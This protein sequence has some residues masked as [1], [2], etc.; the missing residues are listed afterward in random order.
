MSIAMAGVTRVLVLADAPVLRRG[1]AGMIG[2]TAG[3]QAVGAPGEPRRAVTLAESARPDA[4]VV[5]LGSG[6]SETLNACRDLRRRFPRISIVAVATSDDPAVVNE[7]LAAGI[8]GY[9]LMNTSATLLGWAVLAARAGRTVVDPQIRRVE[10]GTV[11]VVRELTP[12]VP[13]TRRESDVLDELVLGQSNRKIGENLF[14]SEDTVKSHVKAILRKLG[15]RDR[16]HAVS[17]VLKAR[18]PGCT[19]GAHDLTA[20]PAQV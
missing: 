1:L 19:C 14:I 11:P 4:V 2:E 8:R 17:L 12:E 15:A 5:E 16:A 20:A 18:T 13:L 9:L 6:R 3:M 10:G 7:A